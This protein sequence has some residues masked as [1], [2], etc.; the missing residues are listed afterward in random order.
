MAFLSSGEVAY[1]VDIMV[2]EPAIALT[3]PRGSSTPG[4][5]KKIKEQVAN[6]LVFAV[7]G[8]V[9]SGTTTVAKKLK[10][11]LS[12]SSLPGGP[13]DV[14]LLKAR[15]EIVEWALSNGHEINEPTTAELIFSERLQDLGDAMR[16]QDL[17]EVARRL[18]LSIRKAR[19]GKQNAAVDDGPVKPDGKRRA[20]IL[21]AIRHPAE[22]HLLRS[23]YRNAF[24]LIGVVCEE[25]VRKD[26]LLN[27]KYSD[28]GRTS[29]EKFMERDAKAKEKYGQRVSDA[30]HLADYFL[31]NS[32]SRIQKD[33]RNSNEDWDIP[34]QLMRL[35][36]IVTHA[37]VVRP[38]VHEMAMNVAY[39]AQMR[40]ACL[41]RQVGA[42]LVDKKGSVVSTGANEVPRGGGGVYGQEMATPGAR[43]QDHRCAYRKLGEQVP[44]C[45]N[46]REQNEI[47]DELLRDVPQFRELVGES[48]E[49]LKGI[50][51][52]SRIGGLI[53]FSRAV[54]A[55]MDALLGAARQ[56]VSPVGGRLYVT[57][58]P[59]HY[60][61]RHIVAAGIDE[62]QYIEPYPKSRALALHDDSITM[63]SEGW[64]SPSS[65][66]ELEQN[67]KSANSEPIE[68]KVLFRPFTGVAPRMYAR[69]FLK[70]RELKSELTGE[71]QFGEPDWESAWD[72]QKGSYAE[73]EAALI[74]G[75]EDAH[76]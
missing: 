20:Y 57:T 73:L 71:L 38:E 58:F 63:R 27:D 76:G 25:D 5:Q 69:A 23:V 37:E 36:E 54:H 75:G 50:L 28:S 55:E 67:Q 47:I 51:R 12:A 39:G 66:L 45:S 74:G 46:T 8:H 11:V 34:R 15:R 3:K 17:A 68:R 14:T 42:A 31:D 7:V 16:K 52:K 13:Y 41:S 6:E 60:C 4:A 32:E 2:N 59:C 29:V 21:D 44:Y 65:V 56:G 35:V 72:I 64:V 49:S 19:A 30:F 22:A 61:A 43:E 70:D 62:V 53:E 33:G 26:R 48:R 1:R 24:A 10:E 9:G 40:S 18:I